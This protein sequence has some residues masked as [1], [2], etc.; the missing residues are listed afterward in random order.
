MPEFAGLRLALTTF[1]MLPVRA[2][3]VDRR[4]AAGSMLWCPLVGA[5]LAGVAAAVLLG[6]RRLYGGPHFFLG[7]QGFAEPALA[8]A[9]A[10]LALALM[11]RGL[12]LDG[13]GAVADR[14]DTA[15]ACIITKSTCRRA[16][17]NSPRAAG[18]PRLLRHPD[19]SDVAVELGRLTTYKQEIDNN[20]PGDPRLC[21]ALGRTGGRLLKVP[22]IHDVGLMEDR[23]TLAHLQPAYG[24]LAPARDR[25]PGSGDGIPQENGR[26]GH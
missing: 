11:T 26:G 22:D 5:A 12:H 24:E 6:A 16:S 25:H 8:A 2:G 20:L 19:H 14:G 9:L 23:A 18:A 17:R 1:T 10:I 15:R 13:L 7:G 21:G 4:S 3:R